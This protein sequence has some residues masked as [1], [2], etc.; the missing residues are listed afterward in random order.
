M[1]VAG[2]T[3]IC[4]ETV[5]NAISVC[6][7]GFFVACKALIT[8]AIATILTKFLNC[9][10]SRLVEYLNSNHVQYLNTVHTGMCIVF[11]AYILQEPG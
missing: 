10:H 1:G 3:D 7:C 8:L 2:L 9:L 4:T 11:T 5:E 6:V